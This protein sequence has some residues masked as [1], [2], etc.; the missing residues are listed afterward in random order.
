[1]QAVLDGKAWSMSSNVN[2]K[3]SKPLNLSQRNLRTRNKTNL[4]RMKL[5]AR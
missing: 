3:I 1:L 5:S 4:M 2:P